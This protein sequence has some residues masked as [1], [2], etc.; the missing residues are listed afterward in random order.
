MYHVGIQLTSERVERQADLP[1][2]NIGLVITPATRP[3]MMT[4]LRSRLVEWQAPQR[5]S[6]SWRRQLNKR[7]T[8]VDGKSK[9]RRHRRRHCPTNCSYNYRGIDQIPPQTNPPGHN[10]LLYW[11][12]VRLL[13]SGVRGQFLI[14]RRIL[15]YG[16][17]KGGVATYG[18]VLSRGCD[19]LRD[20]AVP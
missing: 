4:W 5:S 19:L 15:F 8:T 2:W 6:R 18:G 17:Q 9:M 12:Y 3:A 16:M 14:P 20:T 7:F 1:T 13:G 10:A 11:A